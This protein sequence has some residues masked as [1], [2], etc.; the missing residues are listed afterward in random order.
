VVPGIYTLF[1]SK[2]KGENAKDNDT[3]AER[4]GDNPL[5]AVNLESHESNL[6]YL[7]DLVADAN[8]SVAARTADIE[9]ELKDKMPQRPLITYVDDPSAGHVLEASL[10]ARRG[11]KLWDIVLAIVLAIALFEPWLANRIS[12]RHYAKPSTPPAEF[13][14]RT[15]IAT[16]T[17]AAMPQ[18]VATR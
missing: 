18:E 15:V 6:T 2:K 4:A 9:K 14:T 7:D 12:L 17:P 1:T 16:A 11:V 5:L 8:A 13:A 3:A 10:G